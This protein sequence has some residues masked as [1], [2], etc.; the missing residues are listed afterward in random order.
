MKILICTGIYPP[1]IGGP[2]TYSNLISE[3]LKDQD[4][5]LNRIVSKTNK[6]NSATIAITIKATKLS[7]KK[8]GN[9]F[10]LVGTFEFI[11]S[12]LRLHLACVNNMLT[13]VSHHSED[14]KNINITK[15][16]CYAG[17]HD[18]VILQNVDTLKYLSIDFFGTLHIRS[19]RGDTR[20]ES[21]IVHLDGSP[22]GLLM[23]SA[24]WGNSG[25][26][27]SVN[28]HTCTRTTTSDT[29]ITSDTPTSIALSQ[30]IADSENIL[31]FV[32]VRIM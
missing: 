12:S 22:S 5:S 4:E 6:V 30:S 20:N 9:N 31:T 25:W 7:L 21:C 27:K 8:I 28:N 15:F 3:E 24:N 26:L 10:K 2:A 17:D 14:P 19:A 16:N 32:A 1:D 29:S 23:I 13:L 18:L 11:E